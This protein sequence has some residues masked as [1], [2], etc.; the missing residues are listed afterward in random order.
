MSKEH[1]PLLMKANRLLGGNVLVCAGRDDT[2]KL[3]KHERVA[4]D[5]DDIRHQDSFRREAHS[6]HGLENEGL[7]PT[8]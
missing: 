2:A 6:L 4:A 5:I 7:S 8:R 3:G 1:R